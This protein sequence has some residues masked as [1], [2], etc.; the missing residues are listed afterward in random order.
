MSSKKPTFSHLVKAQLHQTAYL[1]FII[2]FFNIFLFFI[3]I[4]YFFHNSQNTYLSHFSPHSPS[5]PVV[6]PLP[7][8]F[9]FFPSFF[10]HHPRTR[11]PTPYFYFY[12]SLLFFPHHPRTPSL[13]FFPFHFVP[14]PQIPHFL[15]FF[16]FLFPFSFFLFSS[17]PSL[18]S[19]IFFLFSFSIR[20]PPSVRPPPSLC[21]CFRS[22]WGYCCCC[23]RYSWRRR[24]KARERKYDCLI[25]KRMNSCSSNLW[26]DCSSSSV[27]HS[28]G[29][30]GVVRFSEI[31]AI[32]GCFIWFIEPTVN[33]LSATN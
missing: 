3:F 25:V 4:Y 7:L 19:L 5:L 10:S 8:F 6:Y 16:F 24:Q 9:F 2:P 1:N 23:F 13:S 32:F 30:A 17:S 29:E 27:F 18:R 15:S 26:S 22:V 28:F 11:T 33:A 12:F 31:F 21:F 14:L 20:P